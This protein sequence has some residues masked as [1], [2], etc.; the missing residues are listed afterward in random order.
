MQVRTLSVAAPGAV[1]EDLVAAGERFAVVLDGATAEPGVDNGC[2]H[3]VRWLTAEL[4]ARLCAELI[5]D[6]PAPAADGD[7]AA[8][9]PRLLRTAIAGTRQAH[10]GACDLTN[11]RSPSAT[12]A[13]L[14]EHDQALEY[15]LLGDS[16]LL[17]ERPDGAVTAIVD[18]R[19]AA[20]GDCGWAEMR[21]F[22]NVDG[23]FW[24]AG[25]DPEAAARSVSGVLDLGSVR[26]AVLLSDGAYRLVERFG[27]TLPDLLRI[28]DRTGPAGLVAE[29]RRAEYDTDRRLPGKRHDDATVAVC[30]ILPTIDPAVAVR[31][32]EKAQ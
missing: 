2:V 29:T 15:L 7:P 21:H 27:R 10:G 22:R 11:R 5:R 17:V 26:R 28:I 16:V 19:I 14:R 30:D 8:P 32:W 12:V 6:T 24:V 18:D 25:N 3:G 4:G 13:V 20:L 23:G 31:Q 9:L 1:N